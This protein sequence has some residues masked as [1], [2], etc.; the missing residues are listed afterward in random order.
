[1][2]SY[3]NTVFRG[4]K[5]ETVLPE[6]LLNDALCLIADLIGDPDA[7]DIARYALRPNMLPP[8]MKFEATLLRVICDMSSQNLVP[9]EGALVERLKHDYK[10]ARER[11]VS[12][13][14]KFRCNPP[15]PRFHAFN[16]NDWTERRNMLEAAVRIQQVFAGNVGLSRDAYE[17]AMQ[18]M[19][20]VAPRLA[21]V[22]TQ[23]ARQTWKEFTDYDNQLHEAWKT[24][25]ALGLTTPWA[26]LNKRTGFHLE[27]DMWNWIA[28]SKHG[29]STVAFQLAYHIFLNHCKD[30]V[31][32]DVGYFHLE[33]TRMDIQR[34]Y[35]ASQ[36]DLPLEHRGT[37]AI[38]SNEKTHTAFKRVEERIFDASRTA[39]LEYIFCP[40]IGF[41]ELV[42]TMADRKARSEA[43]GRK[44]VA[45]ID[46][47]QEIDGTVF[48]TGSNETAMYNRMATE[49]KNAF[50][51]LGIYGH[52]FA[53]YNIDSD[54]GSKMTSWNGSKL[55]MRSQVVIR[56]E[57][58][59]DSQSDILTRYPD[60]AM[61]KDIMGNPIYFQR[62][63]NVS[64]LAKFNVI[65]ANGDG[66][67]NPG[68]VD[69]MFVNSLYQ[70]HEVETQKKDG[71]IYYVI[72]RNPNREPEKLPQQK[73]L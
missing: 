6:S 8:N 23:N 46:Y 47:Y 7:D 11:L 66:G 72:P 49:L 31:P 38:A 32:C 9:T 68:K 14:D 24:G 16:L 64:A 4:K 50:Q 35:I 63:G 13:M 5:I 65:M 29:K 45:I 61:A 54:Y 58:E 53:Q 39:E 57:R 18:I 27:G 56:I 26:A 12:F 51:S 42:T 48:G 43:R 25:D 41:A 19:L 44:Y 33:T 60:G 59:Y 62:K 22:E 20:D 71:E 3:N 52:V 30:V 21:S 2:K 10:D 55:Q 67:G 69:L 15:A 34:R 1:M 36:I 73:R 17:E 37:L 40:G 70:I 28:K